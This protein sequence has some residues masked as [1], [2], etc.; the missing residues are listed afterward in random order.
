MP[1]PAKL[2]ALRSTLENLR[3][4]LQ[5][6]GYSEGPGALGE[7]LTCSADAPIGGGQFLGISSVRWAITSAAG[8]DGTVEARAELLS[9]ELAG[10][11]AVN[12]VS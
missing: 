4:I 6:P 11:S 2:A 1:S 5:P 8:L 7:L 12:G 10:A 9:P 3:P